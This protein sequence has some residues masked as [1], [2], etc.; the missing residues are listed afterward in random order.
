MQAPERQYK[1]RAKKLRWIA[2]CLAYGTSVGLKVQAR[3]VPGVVTL[4][5]QDMSHKI[6]TFAASCSLAHTYQDRD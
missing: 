4:Q 3:P 2:W 6:Y 5:E 1:P